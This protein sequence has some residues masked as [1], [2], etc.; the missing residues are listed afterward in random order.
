MSLVLLAYAGCLAA[1]GKEPPAPPPHS[2]GPDRSDAGDGDGDGGVRSNDMTADAGGG[3]GG[4][5]SD[6]GASSLGMSIAPDPSCS[7]LDPEKV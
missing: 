2:T 6:A 7:A 5:G 4:S 1:C 3:D